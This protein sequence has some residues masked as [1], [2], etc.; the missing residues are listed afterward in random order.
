[1]MTDTSMME[2][3]DDRIRALID[4]ATIDA[5]IRASGIGGTRWRTVRYDRRTRISTLEV[6]ALVA[7]FPQ[8]AFWINTGD[9]LPDAGQTSPSYDQDKAVEASHG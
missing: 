3:I 2:S 4:L 5:L 1:M 8:Y 6:E 7:V 9:I